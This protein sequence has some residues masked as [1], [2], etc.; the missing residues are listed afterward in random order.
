MASSVCRS[1]FVG[2][3][4]VEPTRLSAL[5]PKTNVYYQFHHSPIIKNRKRVF[6]LSH[7]ATLPTFKEGVGFEPT[8]PYGNGFSE[9]ILLLVSLYNIKSLK[10]FL[11]AVVG[12]EPTCDQLPFLH[13]ISVRGYT[14]ISY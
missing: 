14:A 2:L 8:K 3:V 5:V 1:T 9:Q 11:V 10:E 4:G 6:I 13:G 7:L 12:V